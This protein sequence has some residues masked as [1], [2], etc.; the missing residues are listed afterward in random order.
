MLGKGFS[1]DFRLIF[2]LVS[3]NFTSVIIHY[4]HLKFS[5]SFKKQKKGTD[6]INPHAL[7]RD[8]YRATYVIRVLIISI[9]I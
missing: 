3:L 4:F 7:N 5:A 9:E 6:Y 1:E 8:I 2:L